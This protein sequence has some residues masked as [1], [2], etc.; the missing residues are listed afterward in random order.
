MTMNRWTKTKWWMLAAC[1]ATLSGVLVACGPKEALTKDGN[2]DT[3]STKAEP[4]AAGDLDVAAFK[5]GYD[6]DFFEA[7]GKEFC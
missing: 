4:D 3:A 1:A 2:S 6:I 7:A 5:G